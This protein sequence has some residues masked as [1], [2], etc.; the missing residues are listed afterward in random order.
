MAKDPYS[1]L[2]EL[3]DLEMLSGE[4]SAKKYYD[5]WEKETLA[6]TKRHKI[7]VKSILDL[8][9]GTGTITIWFADRG[10]KAIGLDISNAMLKIAKKK[11]NKVKWLCQDM[12]KFKLY[13]KVDAVICFFDAINHLLKKQDI[14][15]TFDNVYN[16]LNKR[17]IFVFDVNTRHQFEWL[18]ASEKFSEFPNACFISKNPY[19][20]KNKIITFK[21]IWF[22]RK[23]QL[24]ERKDFAV[25]ET[26]YT[27]AELKNMLKKA[28]FKKI[29]TKVQSRR[30]SKPTRM[31]YV[32]VKE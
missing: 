31:I 32:A 11:S 1:G 4:D 2:A 12:T 19:D 5:F 24:Y 21:Q 18:G 20:K 7:R 26:Y 30:K 3:Y 22:I 23:G 25:K 28:G 17:G 29:E 16:A 6:A 14:Q 9:C 27:D 13:K 15:K 8:G 10:Y